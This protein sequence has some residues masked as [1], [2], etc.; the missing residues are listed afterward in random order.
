MP[1][2]KTVG[3]AVLA[4]LTAVTGLLHV[5]YYFPRTVDDL[6]IYL[7]YS[8]NLASG[9]GLVFNVGERVEGFASLPWVFLQAPAFLVGLEPITYTKVLGLLLFAA[10]VTAVALL[11]YE[12]TGRN[13]ALAVFAALLIC[14]NSYLVSWS[15]L[16]LETP[17][18]LAALFWTVLA[19][20][21]FD[22]EPTFKRGTLLAAAAVVLSF[23]RPEAPLYVAAMFLLS[24]IAPSGGPRFVQK[25]RTYPLV[26]LAVATPYLL[27][28]I[29]RYFYFGD[30]VPHL[31]HAKTSGGMDF[32]RLLPL[33]TNGATLPEI[34]FV[35]GGLLLA[36]VRWIDRR[37]AP[38]TGVLAACLVC[39]A[40]AIEDWMPNMRFFLALYPALVLLWIAALGWCIQRIAS[41]R[42]VLAAAL[43]IDL[44]LALFALRVAVMDARL[45]PGERTTYGEGTTW[46][47]HKNMDALRGALASYRL[48]IPADIAGQP[49]DRMG[50]IHQVFDIMAVSDAPLEDSW[51]VG[52]D[53]GKVGYFLPVKVFDTDGLFTPVVPAD[54]RWKIERNVSQSLIEEAFSRKPV[55]TELLSEWSVAAANNRALLEDYEVLTARDG[56]PKN[57]VPRGRSLPSMEKVL[58]R[59]K[60]V[61][62]KIPKG[63]YFQ[64]LHGES[65]GAAMA[66]RYAYIKNVVADHRPFVT[67]AIEP[68]AIMGEATFLLAGIKS[69]GCKVTPARAK[70]GQEIAVTC[71]YKPFTEVPQSFEVFMHFEGPSRFQGD[72]LPVGGLVPTNFWPEKIVCDVFRIEVPPKVKPGPYTLFYGLFSWARRERAWPESA[73]D[74]NDRVIGPEL[75]V[76]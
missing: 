44:V 6:F 49:I 1:K 8:E 60:A 7:R 16:G 63:Y 34:V 45:M 59:Y 27:F 40:A 38:L 14:L 43:V 37:R 51:Y 67:G 72:H 66:R 42:A 33:L 29:F 9:H 5:A 13:R 76:E 71:F 65:I 26:A 3:F 68:G 70:P 2:A 32:H 20:N 62:A 19:L 69:Y 22:A 57:M 48:E 21:A 41:S 56:R 10:L 64:S 24:L 53:I 55:M 58:E 47:I 50:M 11:A 28:L 61:M 74:G 35:G 39:A 12:L 30:L 23:S 17:L 52:R 75:I 46:V 25:L 31:Y 73:T 36:L 18:F 15:M 54:T 4:V